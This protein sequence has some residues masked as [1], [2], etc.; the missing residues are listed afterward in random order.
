VGVAQLVELRV[1]VPAVAGSSPVAHPSFYGKGMNKALIT[2]SLAAAVLAS[3]CGSS[4]DHSSHMSGAGTGAAMDHQ[5]SANGTASGHMTDPMFT[6]QMIPHHQAAIDMA[7]LAPTRAE[8]PEVKT[9]AAAIASAQASEIAL[10]KKVGKENSWDP[11]AKMQHSGSD[12]MSQHEMGMDMDV[13]KLKTA[14][15]F[16]KA[17]IEMMVPHHE[18]AITMAKHELSRGSDSQIQA[19]AER[20]IASQTLQIKQMKQWYQEWYGQQLR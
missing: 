2:S 6:A 14:K 7:E 8:H 17:F 3:G 4:M 15:P 20:I 18:G 19:L 5:T 13:S 1:V 16:D 10:M 12:G 11:N 9:L